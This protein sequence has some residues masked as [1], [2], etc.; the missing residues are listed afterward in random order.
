[1]LP[2]SVRMA[3]KQLIAFGDVANDGSL[4]HCCYH[5]KVFLCCWMPSHMVTVVLLSDTKY[6]YVH[7]DHEYNYI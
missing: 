6:L 2:A 5:I 4:W 3:Y 7:D 1:M